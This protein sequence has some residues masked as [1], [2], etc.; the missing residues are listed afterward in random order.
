MRFYLV[1]FRI[2]L[3]WCSRKWKVETNRGSER[4]GQCRER[5]LPE[6]GKFEENIARV[7]VMMNKQRG[8]EASRGCERIRNLE[9]GLYG[10]WEVYESTC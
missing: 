8:M 9:T 10:N 7:V 6:T 2:R 5:I 4:I 3:V 1:Q